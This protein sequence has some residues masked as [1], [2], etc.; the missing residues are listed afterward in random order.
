MRGTWTLGDSKILGEITY[1]DEEHWELMVAP[2]V[3]IMVPKGTG[4]SF[5]PE[6]TLPAK[7]YAVVAPP[8]GEESNYFSFILEPDEGWMQEGGNAT[9]ERVLSKIGQGWRVVFEGVDDV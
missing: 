8:K 4:F 2:E 1:E 3:E 7:P 9:K 6:V 5:T